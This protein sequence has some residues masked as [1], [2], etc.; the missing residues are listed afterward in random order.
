MF[1]V[2]NFKDHSFVSASYPEEASAIAKNLLENGSAAED[3][4]EIVNAADDECRFTPAE[5]ET[6]W[7]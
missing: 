4:I 5:F 3:D 2:L 1:Y 6:L 7:S